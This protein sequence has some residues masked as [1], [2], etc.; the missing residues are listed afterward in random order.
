MLARI[1]GLQQERDGKFCRGWRF[2]Q[3]QQGCFRESLCLCIVWGNE[4][5]GLNRAA[6]KLFECPAAPWVPVTTR[7]AHPPHT[8]HPTATQQQTSSAMLCS[9]RPSNNTVSAPRPPH[10]STLASQ[11]VCVCVIHTCRATI[12]VQSRPVRA[13]RPAAR[14]SSLACMCQGAR[15]AL[16]HSPGG[17]AGFQVHTTSSQGTQHQPCKNKASGPLDRPGP[18]RSLPP[19][20]YTRPGPGQAVWRSPGQGAT[21]LMSADVDTRAIAHAC[22]MVVGYEETHTMC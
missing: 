14:S 17:G 1:W 7:H 6:F 15:P 11:P 12:S 18:C 20:T 5:A 21:Q 10:P 9:E 4:C 22:G 19:P 13:G 3:A 2:S 8:L 16:T